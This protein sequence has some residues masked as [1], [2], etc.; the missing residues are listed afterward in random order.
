WE[1]EI[2]S[3]LPLFP[4]CLYLYIGSSPLMQIGMADFV[5]GHAMID[6]AQRK[7][8]KYEANCATISNGTIL[9]CGPIDTH[10]KE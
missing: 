9:V 5:P 10:I 7:R 8:V 6:A 3:G 2:L 1:D 4:M